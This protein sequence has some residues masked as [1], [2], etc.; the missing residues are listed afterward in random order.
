MTTAAAKAAAEAAAVL[1]PE[2][3]VAVEAVAEVE[4]SVVAGAKGHNTLHIYVWTSG[5]TLMQL[6]PY[7]YLFHS[8]KSPKVKSSRRSRSR[9]R[10]VSS[11]SRSGSKGRSISR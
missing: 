4:V 8:S 3:R 9:S 6:W 5:F 2:E 7:W 11:R 10:S 1:T